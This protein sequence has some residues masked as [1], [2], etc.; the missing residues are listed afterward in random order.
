MF[1]VNWL[2]PK[3]LI[4]SSTWLLFL[5]VFLESGVLPVPFPG[6][7]LLFIAGFFAST[8]AGGSDPHLNLGLVVIGAFAAAV[9][10]AQIG[11]WIGKFFGTALFKP[12]ARVFKTKYLDQAH[13]FF[14]ER[15]DRAVVIARFIPF[16]R[17]IVPM[18]AGAG[19]MTQRRFFVANVIGAAMWAVGITLLGFFLGKQIGQDNI[20]HYLLPIVGLIIVLSLIPPFLEWRKHRKASQTH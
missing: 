17:T 4:D 7:S 9:L 5:V 12:D 10:G 6:D 11:Y 15:G 19:R 3:D 13:A 20:D 16:V 1:G 14:E 18:I 8:K 2:S